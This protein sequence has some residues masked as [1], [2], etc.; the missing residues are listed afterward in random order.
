MSDNDQLWRAYCVNESAP[1]EQWTNA[2]LTVCP[3]DGGHT[4]QVDSATVDLIAQPYLD[5]TTVTS[6]TSSSYVFLANFQYQGSDFFDPVTGVDSNSPKYLKVVSRIV[7]GTYDLRLVDQNSN[8]LKEFTGLSNT[9]NGYTVFD[10]DDLTG[11][12]PTGQDLLSVECKTSGL[13]VTPV[14]AV[15]Y[16]RTSCR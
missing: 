15:V 2:E 6:I 10:F 14:S 7:G 8:V 13:S 5:L 4:L 9:S 3:N 1:V 16:R 12:L 11:A